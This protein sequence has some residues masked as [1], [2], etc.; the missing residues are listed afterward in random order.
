MIKRFRILFLVLLSILTFGCSTQSMLIK[1]YTP[2]KLELPPEVRTFAVFSR[3]I[4][5]QGEYDRVQWGAFDSIDSVMLAASDTCFKAFSSQFNSYE[6]FRTR[7]PVGE[8]MYQH[9]GTALPDP[10]PWEG[11]L[12]I[13]A[14][15]RT[16]ALVM[17]EAFGIKESE[18]RYIQDGAE[19]K[20]IV[21]M[22]ISAGWR[23]YQPQRR[24]IFDA[25]VYNLNYQVSGTGKNKDEAKSNLPDK[26]NRL[27]LAG[28][29]AG[30]EYAKL[31]K[32]GDLEVKRK[33][34]VKGYEI[35]EEAAVFIEN[36][37]W[38]KAGK[39][40]DYNAYK[41]ET[42]E[43]KAMCSYNMALMSE[44]EGHINKAL[45]F[46]R[47]AQKYLPAKLHI[48]LINDLTIRLLDLEDKYKSGMIIK[49]W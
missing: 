38:G 49:N 47:R 29:Y 16:D 25:K 33:L 6:R 31:M 10:L 28:A 40:W 32:P 41:G 44:K 21:E 19:T 39:K 42:D 46:A 36:N 30:T 15:T 22:E 13:K 9:N 37:E 17:L 4:P 7:M 2:A 18:L 34:Y 14:R 43:L 3:F 20:A 23:I 1:V 48:V 35:I 27:V 12:K 8:R 5:A 26:K 11:L 24:R 45:G